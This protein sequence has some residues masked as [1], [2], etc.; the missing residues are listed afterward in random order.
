MYNKN[1]HDS[2]VKQLAGRTRLGLA[3]LQKL[4]DEDDAQ[5]TAIKEVMSLEVVQQLQVLRMRRLW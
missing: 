5:V 2:T 4:A 3:R 1:P